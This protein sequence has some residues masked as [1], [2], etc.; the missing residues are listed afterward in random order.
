M[1]YQHRQSEDFITLTLK[2]LR[3]ERELYIANLQMVMTHNRF[4]F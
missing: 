3:Q 2:V 4:T 1:I